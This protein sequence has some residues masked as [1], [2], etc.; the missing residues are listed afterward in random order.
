[1]EGGRQELTPI[2]IEKLLYELLIAAT[3]AALGPIPNKA[4][5]RGAPPDNARTI[6]AHDICR[7]LIE[8]GLSDGLH[9]ESAYQS[10]AVELYTII[11]GYIWGPQG[12]PLNPRS[13]FRRL[14]RA[15]ISS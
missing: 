11:A 14:K 10:L 7:A 3:H 13:T 4:A 12:N 2:L 1:V 15:Q 6:L 9:F 8:L 5:S